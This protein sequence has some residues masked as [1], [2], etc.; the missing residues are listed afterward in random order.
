VFIASAESGAALNS[1]STKKKTVK[2]SKQQEEEMD[3]AE[4]TDESGRKKMF[5][6]CDLCSKMGHPMYRCPLLE[7]AKE[8]MQLKQ[9]DKE[10]IVAM[11][12]I[13]SIVL[14]HF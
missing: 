10:H 14:V 3:S 12:Y 1:P 4:Y 11:T 5:Y 7:E 8:Y 13:V 2:Y 6:P 9:D